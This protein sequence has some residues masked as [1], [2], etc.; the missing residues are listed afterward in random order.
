MMTFSS[1][2]L[3]P[4]PDSLVKIHVNVNVTVKLIALLPLYSHSRYPVVLINKI[5]EVQ[6]T[7]TAN[8][9]TET[10]GWPWPCFPHSDDPSVGVD[11]RTYDNLVRYTKY[12]SGAN[13]VLC[14]GPMS[15]THAPSHQPEL[16]RGYPSTIGS[17]FLI[18]QI[19]KQ[20][21][22]R[23]F[24]WNQ[25]RVNMAAPW[26]Q[27]HGPPLDSSRAVRLSCKKHS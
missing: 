23:N 13:P 15:N 17:Q 20:F 12:A 27:L 7:L 1:T 9:T 11:Q 26:M 6:I 5:D 2:L 24:S 21:K 8:E 3:G 18:D 4:R 14:R 16:F 10:T 22:P 19:K 25:T